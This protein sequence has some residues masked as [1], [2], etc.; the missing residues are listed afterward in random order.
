MTSKFTLWTDPKNKDLLERVCSK[1]LAEL[2]QRDL[3]AVMDTHYRCDFCGDV[4]AVSCDVYVARDPNRYI[5]EGELL[6]C[7]RCKLPIGA[8]I[9][10]IPE[11]EELFYVVKDNLYMPYAF[12]YNTTHDYF[13]PH[14]PL[15]RGIQGGLSQK[16]QYHT[17]GEPITQTSGNRKDPFYQIDRPLFQILYDSL[18]ESLHEKL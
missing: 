11:F 10:C 1:T 8:K 17:Q 16:S 12:V 13:I 2:G 9:L 4:I 15:C 18:H 5:R 3:L 7:W 6:K 14:T